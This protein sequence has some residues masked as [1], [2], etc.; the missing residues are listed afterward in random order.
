M[1][2][3][4]AFLAV[5][6]L[7]AAGAVWFLLE[8]PQRFKSTITGQLS[9][10]TGYQVAINGELSWRY[11]PPIAIR[12]GNVTLASATGESIAD[13]DQIEIDVDLMP[14]L[15]GQSLI[16]VN[17]IILS[18]AR[19]NLTVDQSG[20]ANWTVTESSNSDAGTETDSAGP[21]IQ[22]TAINAL[23]IENVQVDYHDQQSGSQWQ[24]DIRSLT[25]GELIERA[26]FSAAFQIGF[27]DL[28]ANTA[29]NLRGTGRL[30][31]IAAQSQLTFN[32]LETSGTVS[33]ADSPVA[34]K[35]QA[36]GEYGL[37]S[38]NL[39][40]ES[41]TLDYGGL[42]VSGDARIA[43]L[44]T[45]FVDARFTLPETSAR[46]LEPLLDTELPIQTI[47]VAGELSGTP[48]ELTLQN[49]AGTFDETSF[50]GGVT[51]L[52]E[53]L[54]ITRSEFRLDKVNL[55]LYTSPAETATS[56]KG[57]STGAATDLTTELIP[58][59][60]LREYA[61]NSII[62][63]DQLSMGTDT[64]ND[65]KINVA[66]DRD[67]LGV[68]AN[69]NTWSGKL[70]VTLDTQLKTPL[71]NLR[72]TL[73]GLDIGQFT[74]IE[75][76]TGKLTANSNLAFSGSTLGELES[77]ITGKTVFTVAEGTLDVRPIKRMAQTIDSIRGQRS[78]ISDWPDS[79]PFRQ[80]TGEHV[81]DSGLRQ[82]QVLTAQVENLN[83]T[84]IGGINL[85]D[86]TL[87]YDVAA[88]FR[89]P[90][91][92]EFRISDQLAGIRWPMTCLGRFTDTPADLCF[93]EEGAISKI[94]AD[95]VRQDLERRGKSKLEELID[96]KIP[97]EYENLTRDLLKGLFK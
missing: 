96:E 29:F 32:G 37:E 69:A 63:I 65:M 95:V 47:T 84:A 22:V 48:E 42:A 16:E 85:A 39:R 72:V 10:Q 4:M 18:G 87:A 62:R 44:P 80:L 2:R 25:T 17:E 71:S 13:I 67:R 77:S 78:S 26:P 24:A 35:L 15:T 97:K 20:Q 41:F 3:I 21:G 61:I 1:G 60:T 81:I 23:K 46:V 50:K 92:G 45:T 89:K 11:W 34:I 68:T 8:N 49:L 57:T 53:A 59:D 51:I 82:G 52:P 9:Q 91:E 38:G 90:V 79:M 70:V 55:D 64:F 27:R 73:D 33:L 54:K 43:T 86:E 36:G 76:V 40:L 28:A 7:L 93:G 6:L 30:Q 58:I 19:V 12:V 14:L 94:V 66:S 74:T 56:S 83:L 88:M 75:G 31:Y 5:L